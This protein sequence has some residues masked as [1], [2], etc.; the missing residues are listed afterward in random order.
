MRFDREVTFFK[1]SNRY[2]PKTGGYGGNA[3][4]AKIL[5]NVT[6]LGLDRTKQLF[7]EVDTDKKVIRLVHP[8]GSAWSYCVIDGDK[9]KYVQV[10]NTDALKGFSMIVGVSHG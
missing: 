7:G 10:S 8:V 3:E 5:A 6:D 1:E 2:N 9:Q 4:V